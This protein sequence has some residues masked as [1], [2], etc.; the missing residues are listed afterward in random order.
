MRRI[1]IVTWIYQFSARFRINN[2]YSIDNDIFILHIAMYRA[3]R[4]FGV[5]VSISSSFVSMDNIRLHS[6]TVCHILYHFQHHTE[7]FSICFIV[8]MAAF[9]KV[10]HNSE[11]FK[12]CLSTITRSNQISN[13]H[14]CRTTPTRHEWIN[15]AWF[16]FSEINFVV[17]DFL[18]IVMIHFIILLFHLCLLFLKLKT[19][20]KLYWTILVFCRPGKERIENI[21]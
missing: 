13:F 6:F 18:V 8:H 17:F 20:D 4:I 2:S 16:L 21:I 1:L 14:S 9:M 15:M 5:I 11:Q 3:D 12:F 19:I 7:L 10:A